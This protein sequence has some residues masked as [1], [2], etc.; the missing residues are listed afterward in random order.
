MKIAFDAKRVF[1]NKSGLGIY[2]RNIIS[3]LLKYYTENEYF[4]FTPELKNRV[5][6]EEEIKCKI[7]SP[8]NFI[9]K[10]LKSFWR[11]NRIY[12]QINN[13][14]IDIY[15]GLS[16]ELP[17]TINKTNT[18]S[19]LTIHDLIFVRHPEL[20]KFFDRKIY[21]QK[22]I[23]SCA[24]ADKIIAIS[25]QTKQDII[26]FLNVD[27]TKIEVVYQGCHNIFKT[28]TTNEARQMVI[29][30]YNLPQNYILNVGTIEKRKNILSVIKA[31]NEY[32]IDIPLVVVGRQT[33]YFNEIQKYII[34]NK[35]SKQIITLH[36]ISLSELHILYQLAQIFVYPS[37][38]EGFGIPIIEALNSEVPVITSRDGCFVEAGGTDSLYVQPTNID[39][40]ANAINFLLN[41]SLQRLEIIKKGVD[42]VKKFDD[43][44]IANDIMKVYF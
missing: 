13:S 20:Y 1:Y 24:K 14:Q 5:K 11:T 31:I 22:A 35:M 21:L 30:K 40:I 42:F 6:F 10:K 29:K 41:N 37:I 19:V 8:N 33:E 16:N 27:V 38:F 4:L 34:Q 26:E 17:K 43:F 12:K 7:V 44:K 25:Q 2:S 32:K 18:K 15:H 23:Y 36:N 39:E 9:D 28:K 3:Y